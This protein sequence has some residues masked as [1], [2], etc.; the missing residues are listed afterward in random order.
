MKN[1]VAEGVA[2]EVN[3]TTLHTLLVFRTEHDFLFKSASTSCGWPTKIGFKIR[4]MKCLKMNVIWP[5]FI[6]RKVLYKKNYI[7]TKWLMKIW[8]FRGT[9]IFSSNYN[10]PFFISHLVF[11]KQPAEFFHSK[12]FVKWKHFKW[13]IWCCN[14]P[15]FERHQKM[16]ISKVQIHDSDL[17]HFTEDRK[18]F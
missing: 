2:S 13:Q 8:I 9:P 1:W 11:R 18:T 3:D 15:R 7:K 17:A 5:A 4:K 6:W 14:H 12:K 16:S 10:V